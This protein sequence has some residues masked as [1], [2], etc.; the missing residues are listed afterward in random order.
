MIISKPPLLMSTIM[1][2]T[3]SR[4]VGDAA[5]PHIPS[6][7]AG[8]AQATEDGATIAAMIDV[9]GVKDIPLALRATEKLR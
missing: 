8:A 3:N 7:G 4:L 1:G 2:V 9:T 5:H 6:S